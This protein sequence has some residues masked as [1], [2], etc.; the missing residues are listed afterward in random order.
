MKKYRI[1]SMTIYF[2][3]EVKYT[4]K[5]YGISYTFTDDDEDD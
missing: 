1:S 4:F 3:L 2:P 5:C